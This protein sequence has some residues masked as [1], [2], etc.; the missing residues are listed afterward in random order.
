MP[1][2]ALCRCE[3][4][5]SGSIHQRPAV[6]TVGRWLTE[7][8]CFGV[9]SVRTSHVKSFSIEIRCDHLVN[10]I[11][12]KM[13]LY[14]IILGA[15]YHLTSS[16]HLCHVTSSENRTVDLICQYDEGFMTSS[17]GVI[18][19]C[20]SQKATWHHLATNISDTSKYGIWQAVPGWNM[21]EGKRISLLRIRSLQPEDMGLYQCVIQCRGPDGRITVEHHM[22]DICIQQGNPDYCK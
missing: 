17:P 20:L 10:I 7:C 4:L 8:P 16:S 22:A 9:Y 13:I 6:V 1:R 12:V 18:H 14:L 3:P 15:F 5:V 11:T 19:T 21:A 2:Y